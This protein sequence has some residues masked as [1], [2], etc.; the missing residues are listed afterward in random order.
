[1]HNLRLLNR[2]SPYITLLDFSP[3]ALRYLVDSIEPLAQAGVAGHA[4]DL[5]VPL[6]LTVSPHKTETAS[7]IVLTFLRYRMTAIYAIRDI[8]GSVGQE[9]TTNVLLGVLLKLAS[10]PV[11]NVRFNVALV[12][13]GIWRHIKPAALTEHVVPALALLREDVDRDV[14][15]YSDEALASIGTGDKEASSNANVSAATAAAAPE[16]SRIPPAVALP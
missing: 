2:T 3:P 9:V 15:F 8:A 11:P 12:L 7:H 13:H 16:A 5:P 4:Q 10:D 1:M 14:R 6:L